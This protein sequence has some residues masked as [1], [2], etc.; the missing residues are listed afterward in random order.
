MQSACL[1]PIKCLIGG[2]ASRHLHGGVVHDVL[3]LADEGDE[4][5]EDEVEDG[6]HQKLHPHTHIP[7]MS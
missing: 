7:L 3:D 2:V 6:A 1:L 5:G 4:G